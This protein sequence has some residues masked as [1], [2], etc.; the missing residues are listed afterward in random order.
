MWGDSGEW[1]GAWS[2]N[3]AERETYAGQIRESFDAENAEA[4]DIDST[5]NDGTFFMTYEVMLALFV[6]A[7]SR[8]MRVV[9]VFRI[10]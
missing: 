5:A 2:D 4:E 3:S 10:G 8:V 9:L 6:G 7:M 1:T